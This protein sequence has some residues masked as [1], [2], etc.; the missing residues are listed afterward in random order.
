M[1][2]YVGLA[3]LIIAIGGVAGGIWAGLHIKLKSSCCACFQLECVENPLKRN[4]SLNT[5]PRTPITYETKE[6]AVS[7]ETVA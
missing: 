5:P 4:S 6:T 2:D 1:V 3:G 7:I